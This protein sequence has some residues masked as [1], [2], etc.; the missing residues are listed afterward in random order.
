VLLL[1]LLLLL[2]LQVS[3]Q[4]TSPAGVEKVKPLPAVV[5]GL[6]VCDAVH[7][8]CVVD[9]VPVLS[10]CFREHLVPGCVEYV[11]LDSSV[12]FWQRD[13]G[14]HNVHASC[15]QADGAGVVRT[16]SCN[17]PSNARVTILY[18]FGKLAPLLV[19]MLI[20]ADLPTVA[21]PAAVLRAM[22][23]DIAT[24]AARAYQP[25]GAAAAND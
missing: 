17:I 19:N 21:S 20:S 12:C 11:Q 2:L 3:Y 18:A 14:H 10:N 13:L 6:G 25:D 22:S 7:Q 24:A 16:G 1:L 5:E 8:D 23:V 15:L 4:M 9:A